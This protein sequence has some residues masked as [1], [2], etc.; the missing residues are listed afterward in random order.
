MEKSSHDEDSNKKKK[1]KSRRSN[2][3]GQ[4]L[5]KAALR[6]ITSKISDAD[7]ALDIGAV[8]KGKKVKKEKHRFTKPVEPKKIEVHIPE[9]ISVSELAHQMSVKAVNVIKE[10]MKI[11]VM[12]TPSCIIEK[13]TAILVTEELGHIPVDFVQT[14]PEDHLS[15]SYHL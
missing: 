2:S 8:K 14:N 10:L 1:K 9:K 6:Q 15:I 4:D 13:D 11:G 12:A 7:D 3:A 5:N